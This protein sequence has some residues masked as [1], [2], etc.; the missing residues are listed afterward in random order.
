MNSPL[1]RRAGLALALTLTAFSGSAAEAASFSANL[2]IRSP[3]QS[4]PQSV[5]AG[6]GRPNTGQPSYTPPPYNYGGPR[7]RVHE[8][9][10]KTQ[11]DG[12]T[13]NNSTNGKL[14]K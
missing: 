8:F 9:D 12:M 2:N 11:F 6:G 10:Y 14:P 3:S 1:L 7:P 4:F 13:E 5:Y